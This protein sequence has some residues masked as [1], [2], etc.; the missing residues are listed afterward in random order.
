MDAGGDHEGPAISP[1]QS[2]APAGAQDANAQQPVRL[3]GRVL[4]LKK[5]KSAFA[6]YF[7]EFMLAAVVT[8]VVV[9]SGCAHRAH[10]HRLLVRMIYLT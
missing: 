10:L 1:S 4:A 5:I 6:F 8:A 3:R 9:G 7:D 2:T